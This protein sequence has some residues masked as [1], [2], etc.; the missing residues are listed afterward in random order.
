M[1]DLGI[2]LD[3]TLP[4]SIE[5][6]MQAGLV[7]ALSA[8]IV[9]IIVVMRRWNGRF[10]N[11]VAGIFTYSIFVYIFTVMCLS[12]LALF[13]GINE[14]ITYNT[15]TYTFLYC[16][17]SAVGITM[18]RALLG[19]ISIG[20]YERKGDVYL[21]GIGLALGDGIV[22]FG[23]SMVANMSY[24]S[25]IN[26]VGL[27][28]MLEGMTEEQ[29]ISISTSIDMLY[30]APEYMWLLMGIAAT[31]DI[32]LAVALSSVVYAVMKGKLSNLWICYAAIIQFFSYISFQSFDYK[33]QTSIIVCFVIKAAI[34]IIAPLLIYK[35]VLKEFEYVND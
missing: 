2:S 1:E 6:M 9:M 3:R 28:S 4:G 22:L 11:V 17:F 18:A 15:Q 31:L 14:A 16:M 13:P 12:I 20:R 27:S 7:L 19:K 25:G 23:L 5:T 32:L 10:V 21:S 24:V 33:S 35:L 34:D 26:S 30:E 8:F 29:M